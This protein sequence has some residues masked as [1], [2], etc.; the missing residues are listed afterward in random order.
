MAVDNQIDAENVDHTQSSTHDPEFCRSFNALHFEPSGQA[1]MYVRVG[2][3][4]KKGPLCILD[5]LAL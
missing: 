4:V 5:T 1:A 3:V 2:S